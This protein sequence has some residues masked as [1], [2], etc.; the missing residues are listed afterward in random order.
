MRHNEAAIQMRIYRKYQHLFHLISFMNAIE[1]I[2]P[3]PYHQYMYTTVTIPFTCYYVP[4]IQFY[5]QLYIFRWLYFHRRISIYLHLEFHNN[6]KSSHMSF[7]WKGKKSIF[8]LATFVIFFFL[9]STYFRQCL[10]HLKLYA[11]MDLGD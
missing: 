8:A 7:L 2:P 3:V 11:C 6:N 10:H 9:F 4:F 1:R 5:C